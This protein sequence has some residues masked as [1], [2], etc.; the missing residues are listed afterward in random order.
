MFFLTFLSLTFSL[1]PCEESRHPICNTLLWTSLSPSPSSDMR[2]QHKGTRVPLL[3]QSQGVPEQSE[4]LAP[5]GQGQG[6]TAPRCP[7]VQ[8]LSSGSAP[9][10]GQRTGHPPPAK[11][12]LKILS[13]GAPGT[14]YPMTVPH[15]SLLKGYTHF[16]VIK[17]M[18]INIH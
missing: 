18:L 14:F 12:C 9:C 4:P 17:T 2:A 1:H 8:R 7:Q 3:Y 16:T 6:E 13:P 11:F 10:S 5:W 15:C